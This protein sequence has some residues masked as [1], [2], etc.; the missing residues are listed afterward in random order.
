MLK[1]YFGRGYM[2]PPRDG[3]R[4]CTLPESFTRYEALQ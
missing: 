2:K 3:L 1:Y 4:N